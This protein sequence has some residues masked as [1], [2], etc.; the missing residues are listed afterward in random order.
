M[1]PLAFRATIHEETDHEFLVTFQAIPEALTGGFSFEE[2]LANAHDALAVAL[3]GYLES[4]WPVPPADA[5]EATSD[6]R[7]PLIP[8]APAVAARILLHREMAARGTTQAELGR[9]MERDEKTVRRIIAGQGVTLGM[10]L[11]ALTALG[12]FPALAG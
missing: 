4:G 3:E 7:R 8:V 2:A 5:V 9:L 1:I 10:T 11:K 12:V 6:A